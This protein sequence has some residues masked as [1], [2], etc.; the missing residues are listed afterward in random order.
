MKLILASSSPARQKLLTDSGVDFQVLV[1]DVDEDAVLAQAQEKAFAAGLG[2]ITPAQ[3]A[4]LLAQAKAQ[5][6]AARVEAADALVLGC[7]SVFEFDGG[8]YG[9]PHTVEKARQRITA[10]SGQSGQLHTGHWL[11][12]TATGKEASELRT[13]IVHFDRL[14]DEEIEAY[15]AT[16]EP[17]W[18]A[19]SFTIDGFGA[20]FIKGIEGEFHTVV[21]LSLNALRSM[22]HQLGQSITNFW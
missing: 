8:A 9:K 22:M 11:I 3:T 14:S 5:D 13:A 20:P 17:L 4:Q 2:E 7:D 15:L 1:S 19:G 10:M 12:D 16:E 18:V 6:V 21:G